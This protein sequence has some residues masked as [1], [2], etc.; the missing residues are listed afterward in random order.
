MW[1][2]CATRGSV[3][4]FF[5]FAGDPSGAGH[6]IVYVVYTNQMSK[7]ADDRRKKIMGVLLNLI[8]NGPCP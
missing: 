4:A 5:E 3:I 8:M 2:Q 7:R 1:P 6:N